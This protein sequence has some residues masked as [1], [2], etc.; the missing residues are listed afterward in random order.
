MPTKGGQKVDIKSQD[1]DSSATKNKR[2]LDKEENESSRSR[3]RSKK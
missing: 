3:K 2:V 1:V